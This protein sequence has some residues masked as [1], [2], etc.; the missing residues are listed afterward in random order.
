MSVLVFLDALL[1]LLLFGE[2]SFLLSEERFA[3]NVLAEIVLGQNLFQVC[4]VQNRKALSIHDQIHG[5]LLGDVFAKLAA[6]AALQIV[7][8][9]DGNVG[10]PLVFDLGGELVR[11]VGKLRASTRQANSSLHLFR[12]H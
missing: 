7:K 4:S 3:V 8:I 5:Q 9:N 6:R 10:F 11:H 2:Q 1:Q 12:Q